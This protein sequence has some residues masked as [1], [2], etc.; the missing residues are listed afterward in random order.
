MNPMNITKYMG[1]SSGRF[2]PVES[3]ASAKLVN[4]FI[5]LLFGVENLSF[6]LPIWST[7]CRRVLVYSLFIVLDY[8]Y[9][10]RQ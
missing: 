6:S 7:K 2:S 5:K 1:L 10:K 9:S 3:T 4:P 8:K